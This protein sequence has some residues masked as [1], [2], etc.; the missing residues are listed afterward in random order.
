MAVLL[1]ITWRPS[2][3][4]WMPTPMRSS[5]SYLQI[6]TGRQS[7]A[8]GSLHLTS[9]VIL[10]SWHFAIPLLTFDTRNYTSGLRPSLPPGKTIW[11]AYSWAANRHEQE[12]YRFSWCWSWWTC[13]RDCG[14]YSSRVPDGKLCVDDLLS[15]S[16]SLLDL[17]GPVL[18][19]GSKLPV[20]NWPYIGS[21]V[22][23]W[24]YVSHKP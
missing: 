22:E 14:L 6:P 11:L 3:H 15:L 24:P 8:Y 5:H 7:L 12:S 2:K 21:V 13:G 20:Q 4:F 1:W 17:G 16:A 10:K 19:N 9:R 23:R 18:A